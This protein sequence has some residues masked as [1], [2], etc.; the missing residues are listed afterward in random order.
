M[1]IPGL[2]LRIHHYILGLLLIPGTAIQTR[3]SL[4]FQG[5]LFGLFVN[6][7]AR[8]GFASLLETDLWLAGRGPIG[9]PLPSVTAPIIDGANITISWVKQLA[10]DWDGVSVR[11]NDVERYRWFKDHGPP[12]FTWIR[13]REEDLY[14]RFGLFRA[15]FVDGFLQGD[16][17]Q[18]AVW[19]MNGSWT[20]PVSVA[21]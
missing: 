15:G 21:G 2:N 3:P 9:S 5:L 13:Q 14:F 8:W 20:G 17:T 1:F 7:V 18:P 10:K 6:G 11:V 4:F 19:S 16:Y 12:T